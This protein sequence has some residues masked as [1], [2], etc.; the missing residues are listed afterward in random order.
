MLPKMRADPS[1][2]IKD[3]PSVVKAE[4]KRGMIRGA[5]RLNYDSLADLNKPKP[6]AADE[7]EGQ[8]FKLRSSWYRLR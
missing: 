2:V 7:K 1:V 4:P 8:N 5:Q 6:A 3:V